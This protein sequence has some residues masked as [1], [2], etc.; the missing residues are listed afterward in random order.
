MTVIICFWDYNLIQLRIIWYTTQ[1]LMHSVASLQK[2]TNTK[3]RIHFNKEWDT[4]ENRIS[5]FNNSIRKNF[6]FLL[7]QFL[8]LSFILQAFLTRSISVKFKDWPCV[9][10]VRPSWNTKLNTIDPIWRVWIHIHLYDVFRCN[11]V[12]EVLNFDHF[13]KAFTW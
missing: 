5:N 2:T 3:C 9:S 13:L 4:K 1:K 7:K 6:I 8:F 10:G 12:S 11:N